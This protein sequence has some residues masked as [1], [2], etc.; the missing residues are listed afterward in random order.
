MEL[1]QKNKI[2]ITVVI[3]FVLALWA[4]NSFFK[5]DSSVP[6]DAAAQ[7]VGSDVLSLY[8][9]LQS[10]TLE[11]SLFSSP[12]YRNLIDFSTPLQSQPVGRPNPFAVI[13]QD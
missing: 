7:T 5:V 13:G 6:T 11:Q 2:L 10:V 4:Y 1:L 9:S 3:L 12:L 8:S